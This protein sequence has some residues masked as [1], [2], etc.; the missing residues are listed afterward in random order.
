VLKPGQGSGS[1]LRGEYFKGPDLKE[2]IGE[3]ID[4]AVDFAWGNKP[5]LGPEPTAT[6]ALQIEVPEGTWQVEWLDTKS[7]AVV[8]RERVSGAGVRIL[9][10]PNFDEDIALRLLKQ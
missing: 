2:R 5:P 1:G 4:A 10:A 3:R 8:S 7:G 6:S 9:H